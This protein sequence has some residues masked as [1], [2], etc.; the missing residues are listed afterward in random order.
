MIS[1]L[2]FRRVA[3]RWGPFLMAIGLSACQHLPPRA[4]ETSAP[5]P[6]AARMAGTVAEIR[7]APGAEVQPGEWVATLA[8][9]SPL[10]D[11]AQL[12]KTLNRKE[13]DLARARTA[14]LREKQ[15]VERGQTFDVDLPA[16]HAFETAETERNAALAELESTQR[17]VERLRHYAP[18]AGTVRP[19][20]VAAGQ[21][22]AAGAPLLF[23]QPP[24]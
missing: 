14:Y 8:P 12:R 24:P 7:V 21:S 5:V 9:A 11:P 2:P 17:E 18:C 19:G 13:D 23:I 1:S 3:R 22:V 20:A 16:R 15:R 10:S 6:V 4:P